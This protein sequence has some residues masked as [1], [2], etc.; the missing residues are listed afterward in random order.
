M[1]AH[2]LCPTLSTLALRPPRF[3]GR[4]TACF[5]A[6]LT[7]LRGGHPCPSRWNWSSRPIAGG[8]QATRRAPT[9][10]LS[11]LALAPRIHFSQ[12]ALSSACSTSLLPW[13]HRSRHLRRSWSSTPVD[14]GLP[15]PRRPPPRTKAAQDDI[16]PELRQELDQYGPPLDLN[17]ILFLMQCWLTCCPDRLR[18]TIELLEE[19]KK[20]MLLSGSDLTFQQMLGRL[21]I[22]LSH[23]A[24]SQLFLS[25]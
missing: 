8:L 10:A 1:R 16:D 19:I 4:P 23:G 12:L 3:A 18:R 24:A 25:I 7:S 6:M 17:G 5:S 14:D 21:L 20:G 13:S 9:M 22:P 15:P 2:L 11:N